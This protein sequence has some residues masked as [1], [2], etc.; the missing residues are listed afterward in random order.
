MKPIISLALGLVLS[1]ALAACS[2]AATSLPAVDEIQQPA[3]VL[4]EATPT[5]TP[6]LA[7]YL[8]TDYTDAASLRNQL[9]YGTLKLE[10]TEQA[11]TPE[12]AKVLLPLWQA[13]VVLSGNERTAEEELTAVQNQITQALT[14]A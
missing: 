11:I 5:P 8:G 13:I 3:A 6:Y 14:P 1:L 12:Q 9:A 7:T 10:G 2:T 4:G